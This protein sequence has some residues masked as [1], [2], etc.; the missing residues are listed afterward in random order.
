[1]C[2]AE[3]FRGLLT[4][5]GITRWFA[6][7]VATKVSLVELQDV[8]V[9]QALENEEEKRLALCGARHARGRCERLV[10]IA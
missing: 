10:C 2:E 6:Y 1:M 9:K 5:N 4:E 3:R 7:H 8:H